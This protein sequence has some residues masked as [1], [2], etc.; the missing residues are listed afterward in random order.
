MTVSYTAISVEA[1]SGYMI[2]AEF[3]RVLS[4]TM[5][6]LDAEGRPSAASRSGTERDREKGLAWRK[7]ESNAPGHWAWAMMGGGAS[8]SL[9]DALGVPHAQR[10]ALADGIFAE[11]SRLALS[12][13]PGISREALAAMARAPERKL[14]TYEFFAAQGDRGT[15]RR[16]AAA[17]YPIFADLF[18]A[19]LPT[20]M[21]IDRGKP[22]AEILVPLLSG[23]A[24]R[25]VG[26]AHLKRLAQAAAL[27]E[28]QRLAPVVEFASHL[29][30][31]WFPKTGEEW[32][33]FHRFAA[34]FVED[35]GAPAESLPSLLAGSGG[36]WMD[37]ARRML[38]KAYSDDDHPSRQ[39]P[40]EYIRTAMVMARDT[41]DAFTDCVILPV[42]AHAQEA[43]DVYLNT[44]IRNAAEAWA[45]KMLF[46]GR[47]IADIAD[48]SRRFHQERAQMM[49]QNEEWRLQQL[50]SQVAEG[51]WPGLTAAVEAPNGLWLVPLCNEDELKEEG[52]R[53]RHC[54][55]GYG[56][57]AKACTSHIVSVRSVD[58]DGGSKS[59]STC[60]FHG[61]KQ[62]VPANLTFRQHQAQGNT[63]PA[64]PYQDAIAW[65]QREIVSGRL[66]TNWEL[67]RA[68]L[69]DKIVAA[70]D[71]VERGCGFD[72]RDRKAL[73]ASVAPWRDFVGK[74]YRDWNL[75]M[76]MECDD[77][78]AI[79]E[80]MTP[81][82]LTAASQLAP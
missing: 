8:P 4:E 69:D 40:L 55:G 5:V 9:L 52:R 10:P 24:G 15:Y 49:E 46:D 36:K 70:M 63:T 26:N 6:V 67:I 75:K 13:M 31:D 47:N 81:A 14:S 39:F 59:H 68:F 19:S 53:M 42:L 74:K 50:K 32:E 54:V 61:I 64:A 38:A 44:T 25:P 78:Q 79:I 77:A 37:L 65:Y 3:D 76:M 28:G 41:L 22:L 20:K 23:M 29:Q 80:M 21:A 2:S 30:P 34:G 33:A 71:H 17:S 66:E 16:Q 51:A 27:P 45:W 57:S 72:W 73:S 11:A 43:D 7:L 12:T 56:A 58:R 60:E 62:A 35:L 82:R 1:G 18:N 48:L